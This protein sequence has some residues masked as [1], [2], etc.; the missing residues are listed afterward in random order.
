MKKLIIILTL[1]GYSC[2]PNIKIYKPIT[3]TKIEL[4]GCNGQVFET[5]EIYNFHRNEDS[6][7]WN[8]DHGLVIYHGKYRVTKH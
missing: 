7:Q 3:S 5:H 6:V 2:L 1:F 8:C 4:L